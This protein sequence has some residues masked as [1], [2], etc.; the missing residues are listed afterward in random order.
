MAT[1]DS[2]LTREH[3]LVAELRDAFAITE[4]RLVARGY[5]EQLT[6]WSPDAGA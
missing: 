6:R 4:E 1:T 5:A 3:G 2:D